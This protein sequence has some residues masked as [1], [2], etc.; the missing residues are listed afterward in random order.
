MLFS[1]GQPVGS[2][3]G[4]VKTYYSKSYTQ[5]SIWN[6]HE[7]L[8]KWAFVQLGTGTAL[9]LCIT[10]KRGLR[11]L[12]YNRE[13]QRRSSTKKPNPGQRCCPKTQTLLVFF[14]AAAHWDLSCPHLNVS[15]SLGCLNEKQ[16]RNVGPNLPA[17]S[18][19]R[20]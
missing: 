13:T 12:S 18:C 7:D 16:M 20:A 5:K 10:L 19:F 3:S 6:G 2:T 11:D 9:L 15:L 8:L 17:C 14:T 4:A 1:S